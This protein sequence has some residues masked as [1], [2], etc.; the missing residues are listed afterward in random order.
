[1]TGF[2][3]IIIIIALPY[4]NSAFGGFHGSSFFTWKKVFCVNVSKHKILIHIQK[5]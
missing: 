3:I 2:I 1:M 4:A 5:V